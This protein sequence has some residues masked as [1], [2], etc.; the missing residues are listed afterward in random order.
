MES[1]P[2]SHGTFLFSVTLSSFS[3]PAISIFFHAVNFCRKVGDSEQIARAL[4]LLWFLLLCAALCCFV[5]HC[6]CLIQVFVCSG[7]LQSQSGCLS[8]SVGPQEPRRF[9]ELK[10]LRQEACDARLHSQSARRVRGSLLHHTPPPGKRDSLPRGAERLICDSG[11]ECEPDRETERS[12]GQQHPPRGTCEAF[13]TIRRQ[14]RDKERDALETPGDDQPDVRLQHDHGHGM[15]HGS[16]KAS[17]AKRLQS[18]R[19]SPAPRRSSTACIRIGHYPIH[20]NH[21]ISVII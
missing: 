13:R 16:V 3:F 15:R 10:L 8:G 1:R 5:L 12:R 17:A 20:I 19:G 21:L 18:E 6:F 2:R 9:R 4:L 11:E 7:L 14:T